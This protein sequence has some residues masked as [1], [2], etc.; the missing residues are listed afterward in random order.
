YHVLKPGGRLYI[1][2]VFSLEGALTPGEQFDLDQFDR[3]YVYRTTTMSRTA[4]VLQGE[5]FSDV[6]IRNLGKHD[7]SYSDKGQMAVGDRFYKAM[8]ENAGGQTKL[9]DFGKIHAYNFRQ[10]PIV[11]GEVMASK[12][13]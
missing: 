5:G 9:T 7:G 13:L 8:M 1:K 3:I 10:L 11:F 12:P 6:S 2:D 4:E